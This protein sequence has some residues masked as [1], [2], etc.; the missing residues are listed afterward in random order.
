MMIRG[1]QIYNFC[2][3]ISHR[4]CISFHIY[5]RE[6]KAALALKMAMDEHYSILKSNV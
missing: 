4:A 2:Y 1:G 6:R 5:S 3:G